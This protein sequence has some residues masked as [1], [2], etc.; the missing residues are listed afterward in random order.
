M[1]CSCCAL[2]RLLWNNS[3]IQISLLRN[4]GE[5]LQT[6]ESQLILRQIVSWKPPLTVSLAEL[7]KADTTVYVY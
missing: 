4:I 7:S 6:P 3:T 5:E 1:N 2:Y